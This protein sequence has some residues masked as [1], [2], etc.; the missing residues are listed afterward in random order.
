[1]KTC[2]ID[3]GGG[4]RGV[5]GAG[6]FDYCLENNINFDACIGISAGSA[7][8][9]TFLSKQ[10]KRTYAFY[11]HY[12]FR[13]EYMSL[14]NLLK[15]GHYLDLDYIYSTLSNEKGE[16]PLDYDTLMN[17]PTEL[18]VIATEAETGNAHYFTKA[19]LKRN[20]YSPL[21]GSSCL[22]VVSK[23]VEIDGLHY[24]DGGLSDPVP[25]QFALD[26]GFDKI[27]LIWTKPFTLENSFKRER[28]L[29]KMMRKKYPKI[30]DSLLAREEIVTEQLK[31]AIKLRDEGKLIIIS[32]DDIGKMSTLT[33]DRNQ[34]DLMY[35]K[36]KEDAEKIAPFLAE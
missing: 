12:A 35:D 25:I 19:D 18:Y 21:K 36:G 8:T 6:V 23:S 7:N 11:L 33:K 1:M 3:T 14:D 16:Y 31:L 10:L 32:P 27:V 22:P 29:S 9:I 24:Y 34:L 20:D 4:L 26:L 2:I 5:Y 15:S 30:A 13:K 17:N 28:I